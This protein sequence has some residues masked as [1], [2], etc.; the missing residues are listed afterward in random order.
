MH[1]KNVLKSIV[2]NY[3]SWILLFLATYFIN[4]YTIPDLI[5]LIIMLMAVHLVHYFSH[6]PI[7]YPINCAHLYHHDNNNLFS[8]IIQMIIEFVFI[9]SP[10]LFKYF[11]LPGTI[12]FNT[13]LIIFIYFFYT[14]VHTVNYSIF[15]INNIHEYHH[16]DR[17]KNVGPD[18]CDILFNT[19]YNVDNDLENTDHYI[20]NIIASTILIFIL[21]YIFSLINNETLVFNY[22]LITMY[23]LLVFLIISSIFIFIDDINKYLKNRID[24]FLNNSDEKNNKKE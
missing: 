8:H 24:D 6:Y 12:F 3:K 18:I 16:V 1:I 9:L 15:H 22:F 17:L 13:Y 11:F 4:C 21:K 5:T 23:L 10:I 2:L 7:F 14:T 20:P 19:K